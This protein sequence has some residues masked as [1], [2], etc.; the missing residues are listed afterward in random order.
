MDK[1]FFRRAAPLAM[2]LLAACG[3]G[4]GGSDP[5][6]SAGDLT[7]AGTHVVKLRNQG[8]AWAGLA[9]RARALE[10]NTA[11]ERTLLLAPP[12]G[13]AP[14]R[15]S[16]PAGWSLIDFVLHPSRQLSVVLATATGL[17]LQRL[18]AQGQLLG[19]TVFADPLAAGDPMVGDGPFPHDDA[20]LLPAPTRDAVRLAPAGERLVMALRSGRHAVVAYGLQFQ[21]GAGFTTRW[22]TLVEPGVHIE[23]LALTSGRFDPFN[24]IENQWHVALDTAAD[25]RVAVAVS[26]GETDLVLGHNRHFGTTIPAT[27]HDGLLLTRLAADGQRL[28]TTLVETAQRSELHAL[29]WAGERIAVAGRVRTVQVDSGWDGYVAFVDGGGV[30]LQQQVLDV[31]RGDVILDIAALD[32]GAGRWLLAGSTG[33]L[34]NPSGASISEDASPLLALLPAPG[35]PAQR[36]ALGKGPRHNQARALARWGGHWWLGGLHD[37]PGTHSAD[38]D[39]ALLRADGSLRQ[40]TLPVP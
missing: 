3:G 10:D 12:A 14:L 23:A 31:D 36:L 27:V 28:G 29:R 22:R 19:D 4:G 24:S 33:Y 30:L 9:Q 40:L 1:H 7:F 26:L 15:W 25:G 11:P 21:P 2:L 8:D 17:R 32:D 13:A 38:A 6:P 35:Q 39:P 18:D 16:P 20:S 34:Q 37:G 5:A